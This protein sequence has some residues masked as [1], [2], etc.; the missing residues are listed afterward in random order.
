MSEES[1]TKKA[2]RPEYIRIEFD[3]PRHYNWSTGRCL[4]KVYAEAKENKKMVAPRCPNCKKLWARPPS[5]VC[6]KC[7]VDM[8]WDWVELP[9]T[10]TIFQYTYQV[11]PGDRHKEAE[12]GD[13]GAGCVGRGL[14]EARQR[15]PGHPILQDNRR[16]GG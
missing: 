2:E 7:K 6:P 13:A 11:Y 15:L 10:G 12:R 4:G 16:V 5:P 1:P 14:R 8:G 9:L 3:L